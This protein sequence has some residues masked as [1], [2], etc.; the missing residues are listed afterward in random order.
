MAF[1]EASA[2]LMYVNPSRSHCKILEQKQNTRRATEQ[3]AVYK[4]E[5]SQIIDKG[6]LTVRFASC[7][8]YLSVAAVVGDLL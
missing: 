8:Q 1:V 4:G 5:Y 3:A 7:L 2:M 6:Y